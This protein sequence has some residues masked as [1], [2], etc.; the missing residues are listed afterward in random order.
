MNLDILKADLER[1]VA[2]CHDATDENVGDM[3]CDDYL[4][5]IVG[6]A[7]EFVE[8]ILSHSMVKT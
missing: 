6:Y 8:A 5:D 2:S 4:E 1:R 7:S 3:L